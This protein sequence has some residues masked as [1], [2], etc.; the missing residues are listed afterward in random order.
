MIE[1]KVAG[2]VAGSDKTGVRGRVVSREDA[3]VEKAFLAGMVFR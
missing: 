3:L 2:F 1:T